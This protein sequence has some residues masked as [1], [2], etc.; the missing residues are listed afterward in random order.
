MDLDIF[1]T[2][3]LNFHNGLIDEPLRI[4]RDDGLVDCHSPGIYFEKEPFRHELPALKHIEGL[5][6]DVGCGAGR[7]LLWLEQRG[8]N[9]TGVDVSTGAIETCRLRGCKR[10][11]EFDIMSKFDPNRWERY[12]T[13]T[14]FG[15][16]IGI[17]G[18][19]DGACKLFRTLGRIVS[20]NGR[21]IVTG[22]DIAKT[23]DP[24]HLAY[25]KRN[26]TAGKRRGEI[27]MQFEYRGELG[28]TVAWYHPEPAEVEEIAYLSG[29]EIGDMS[30][31]DNGFFLAM[32]QR[33]P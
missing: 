29:W 26:L 23:K 4:H 19:F 25:H 16:N 8:I 24:V 33:R 22:I 11:V 2:A 31:L 3:L 17:G 30:V 7:H 1:G 27:M 10:V 32:L 9:A 13:V 20:E 21:L 12:K 18:T 5:V 15:N 28:P 14:L 6:L